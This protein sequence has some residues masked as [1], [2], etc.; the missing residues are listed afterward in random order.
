MTLDI[1]GLS[2]F[3][4]TYQA[5]K[6][7]DLSV[8][9]NEFVCLLGPSGCGKTTLLRAIAGLESFE[10]GQM[11]LGGRDLA[12]IGARDRGFGI[13][14]QSYSLFPHMT[15]A[16]NIGYGLKL[17]RKSPTQISARVAE[18]LALVRLEDFA[19]RLPWQ[20]SGGQQQRVAIARALA[21]EPAL[22]L[23]DEPLSALDARVRAGLRSE[24]RQMQ[25]RLG[26]P[27][28]MVT[29]DQ[30]EALTMADKVVCMSAGRI[31]QIGSPSEIYTR[32]ATRFVADFV[33]SSTLLSPARARAFGAAPPADAP[34]GSQ[35]D[36]RL[37]ALR[38]ED[39]LI[40]P[41]ASAPGLVRSITFLGNV[42]R[43]E[44]DWQGEIILAETHRLP[45]FAEGATVSLSL[46]P[47][48]G[49]WVRA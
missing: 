40:R 41:D 1:R 16:Q 42:S 21:A 28:I 49:A 19:D 47:G 24:I 20:L 35:G 26:I 7:I 30:E 6:D 11:M 39:V 22:L 25:K 34:A 33:G 37:F 43:I 13:V 32:P 15:V 44:V 18:M 27:T 46:Q 2:K 31:E 17:R 4:G 12:T 3:Y 36:D 5:L 14:F 48:A 29:H 38:P 9:E 45:E 23:L 8:G 10:G